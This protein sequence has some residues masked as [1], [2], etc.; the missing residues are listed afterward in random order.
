MKRMTILAVILALAMALTAC[1]ADNAPET[2]AA[3]EAVAAPTETTAPQS[4]TLTAWEMSASTW[5]SPNGATINISATP[6]YTADGQS[7]AFV[8]RLEG[9]EIANIPCEFD[10]T[11]YTASAD[12]NAA[13]GYCYY[14]VL[15]AADGTVTE[16]AVNTATEPT[17]EAFVNMEASLASYCSVTVEESTFEGNTLELS[18]CKIQVQAPTITDEGTAITCQQAFLFLSYN[19]E[20]LAQVVVTLEDTDT[21][22]LFEATVS[23]ITFEI[24]EMEDDQKVELSLKVALSNGQE[25]SAYGGNWIYNEEGLLPVVG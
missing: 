12:L 11:N 24:P 8:V 2:T 14:V 22:G 3:T 1:G 5:S 7:A 25:L 15:T 23:G 16:V 6:N 9:D 10:G 19:G 20:E 4:L 18:N 21:A 13:D 17:N